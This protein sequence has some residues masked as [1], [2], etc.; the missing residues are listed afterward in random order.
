MDQHAILNTSVHQDRTLPAF[1]SAP[2]T[3]IVDLAIECILCLSTL[4][5]L[6]LKSLFSYPVRLESYP[7]RRSRGQHRVRTGG[8]QITFPTKFKLTTPLKNM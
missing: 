3:T 7:K 1:L 4:S 2:I 6:S 5:L 8:Y